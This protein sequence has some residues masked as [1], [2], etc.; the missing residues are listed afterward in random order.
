MSLNVIKTLYIMK[1]INEFGIWQVWKH[2]KTAS[3]YLSL[4]I[5]EINAKLY[6]IKVVLFTWLN[7]E[8]KHYKCN[9]INECGIDFMVLYA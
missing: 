7:C 1:F 8:Q 2:I 5:I 6:S 4:E 9:F 3:S